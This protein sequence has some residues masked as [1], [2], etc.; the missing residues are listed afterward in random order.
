MRG[1]CAEAPIGDMTLKDGVVGM[2]KVTSRGGM[3]I[4]TIRR[5]SEAFD[6]TVEWCSTR[7]NELMHER[8]VRLAR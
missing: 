4:E 7:S 1:G 5:S 3:S 6:R 2:M 8:Y